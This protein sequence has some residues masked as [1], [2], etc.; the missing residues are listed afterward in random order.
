M[1]RGP[2]SFSAQDSHKNFTLLWAQTHNLLLIYTTRKQVIAR[3]AFMSPSPGASVILIDDTAVFTF[4]AHFKP[5]SPVP[6]HHVQ[7]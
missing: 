6:L 3:E 1:T 5:L 7:A 4:L 2:R